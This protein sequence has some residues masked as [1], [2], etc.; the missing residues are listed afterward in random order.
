MEPFAFLFRFVIAAAALSAAG[1]W[2]WSADMSGI[3]RNEGNVRAELEAL[4]RSLAGTIGP[5]SYQDPAN[6]NAAADFIARRL[7][8]YGYDLTE[9]PYQVGG[10]AVRNIIA[11]RRGTDQPDRVIVVGAHYDTV[12]GSPGADDNASGVAVLLELARLHAETRFRKTVRF[13]AFTLEEP[14][15]FRSRQMGSRVYAR[16][17]KEQGEHVEA[18]LCLESVGYYSQE[19]GSQSFPSLV[20]WLRWRYPTTGNFITIVSD[21]DSQPLQTQVRDG[22]VAHMDLPVETYAGPW[23]I[24]GVDWSDHGSFWNEGY[25]AVMLTDTALFRNP[26]YHR[27]TDLPDTLDYRAMSELVR[28]LAAALVMLDERR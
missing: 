6:L 4:V 2:V 22:L 20:F 14:P 16:L 17:L 1:G 10:L 18:M 26:H 19:P 11:E 28:G 12:V 23:W 27:P 8:S 9:Q 13:V 24:P 15:F 3:Q 25:P 7:A 21:D 5:R